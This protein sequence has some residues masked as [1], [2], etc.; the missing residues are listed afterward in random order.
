MIAAE[1]ALPGGK[2]YPKRPIGYRTRAELSAA[3]QASGIS[4]LYLPC[5]SLH[6]ELSAALQASGISRLYLPMSPLYLSVSPLLPRQAS[7]LLAPPF[8][9][10]RS[11]EDI[12]P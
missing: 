8:E 12:Y 5:I 11:Q 10:R 1:W 4:P 7:G 3:L 6:L 2:S 9:R